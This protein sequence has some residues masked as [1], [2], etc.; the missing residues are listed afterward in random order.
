MTGLE[1]PKRYGIGMRRA[2]PSE[3]PAASGRRAAFA[4]ATTFLL[5]GTAIGL[6]VDQVNPP[7]LLGGA[8]GAPMGREV[9]YTLTVEEI[10]LTQG[11]A[12]WPAWTF[13]GQVPG[14]TLTAEVGDTL[15]VRVIN[16]GTKVHSFHTH[17][18]VYNF[19]MDGSQAN[20]ISGKGTGAM[21][22]P[23]A[24]YT[25]TFHL[26]EPGLFY[27]HCHSADG[28]HIQMHIRMGLYGAIVV[29]DPNQP[30]LREEVIFYAEAQPG[31]PAFYVINN[32]G[33]P[34]GE[35]ALEAVYGEQG[36][37][38]V[39]ALLNVAVTAFFFKVGETVKLHL[40]NIGDIYHSHHGHGHSHVST[41]L[42][43]RPW[44]ANVVPLV[45]GA[46]DTLTVTFK[47]PGLWLFHCHV[48]SHADNGMI[49]LFI[50]E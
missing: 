23:G 43:G 10:T 45:P 42:G 25:Y 7:P 15:N 17:L 35:H 6:T 30:V 19:T 13:N 33:I 2:R 8:T 38:G 11:D 49:G 20:T 32:R 18:T 26:T 41:N 47:E 16:N 3:R 12:S 39:A 37:A 36:F 46:A 34:G 50:V 27:Y 14:P 21:I 29:R 28:A 44:V 24:E 22:A 31:A 4:V 9:N 5:L 1:D 40:V 48:V